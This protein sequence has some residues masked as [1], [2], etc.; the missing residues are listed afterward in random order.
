MTYETNVAEL[1]SMSGGKKSILAVSLCEAQE[2]EVGCHVLAIQPNPR[3]KELADG[4]LPTS[5]HT[6]KSWPNIITQALF[7]QQT[8]VIIL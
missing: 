5:G 6:M 7:C 8:N 1:V 3:G 2:V 4:F